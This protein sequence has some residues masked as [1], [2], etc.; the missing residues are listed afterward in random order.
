MK[1]FFHN[2][3]SLQKRREKIS[4]CS[5][6]SKELNQQDRYSLP[7]VRDINHKY[8]VV[9]RTFTLCTKNTSFLPMIT[10]VLSLLT[11]CN[12]L[13]EQQ[14]MKIRAITPMDENLSA[15]FE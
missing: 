14:E 4:N 6:H 7:L 15:K 12:L 3:K 5:L 11:A 13:Q 2:N 8:I 9:E 10:T 1:S